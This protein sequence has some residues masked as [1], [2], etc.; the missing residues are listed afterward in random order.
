MKPNCKLHIANVG[1]EKFDIRLEMRGSNVFMNDLRGAE[2]FGIG[3]RM[4]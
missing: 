4:L 1:E 3:I 2:E